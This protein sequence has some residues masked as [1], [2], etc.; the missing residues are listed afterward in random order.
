MANNDG[1]DGYYEAQCHAAAAE[2]EAQ[3]EQDYQDYLDKLLKE[4]KTAL[5]ASY[6]ALDWLRSKEFSDSCLTAIQFIEEQKQKHQRSL[7]E[8]SF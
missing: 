4:G 1:Y 7:D 3:Q 2:A 5:F 6:I 8:Q